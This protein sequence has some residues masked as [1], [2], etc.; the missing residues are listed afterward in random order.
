MEI[1]LNEAEWV[2]SAIERRDL[3]K[4]PGYTIML[5][6]KYLHELGMSKREMRGKIEELLL[7][8]DSEVNLERYGKMISWA[9][10]CSGDRKLIRVNE[11][12]VTE[13][14]IAK[15][16]AVENV[17]WQRFLFAL[18]CLAKFRNKANGKTDG[19]VNIDVNEILKMANVSMTTKRRG[20]ML[21][22]L[23][24]AGYIQMSERVDSNSLRVLFIDEESDPV[25][26]VSDFRNLGYRYNS[27]FDN[28]Y[29]ECAECG[30]LV[31]RRSNHQRYC[32][33]CS[34]RM[35]AGNTA[36]RYQGSIA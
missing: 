34:R 3:G 25:I 26:L 11:V 23:I 18:L 24:E 36:K 13:S 5:Y 19:W 15:I 17:T 6:A 2:M 4:K 28:R 22:D 20:L 32:D 35:S 10:S 21:H 27:I 14:E 16:R 7:R 12:P 30:L 8:C 9:I 33:R 31:R 1:I 29:V